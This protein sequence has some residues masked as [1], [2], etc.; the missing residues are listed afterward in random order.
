M[1]ERVTEVYGPDMKD[2][3]RPALARTWLVPNA[4]ESEAGCDVGVPTCYD[5]LTTTPFWC[6]NG[7]RSVGRRETSDIPTVDRATSEG[8]SVGRLP[9]NPVRGNSEGDNLLGYCSNLGL[10]GRVKNSTPGAGEKVAWTYNEQKSCEFT[11]SSRRVRA[12]F[13]RVGSKVRW[14]P[15]RRT[16]VG[17]RRTA[18]TRATG[19]GSGAA[20]NPERPSR[21]PNTPE[22]RSP[23]Y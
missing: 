22:C 8:T 1:C 17:C 13:K 14:R 11:T 10:G 3:D 16:G 23:R 21:A 2:G 20:P 12:Q 15:S 19:Y 18:A 5:R 4:L 7:S 6:I 9:L